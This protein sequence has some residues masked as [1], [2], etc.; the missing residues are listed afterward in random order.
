MAIEDI[1]VEEGWR[2]L[3]SM[4]KTEKGGYA[5]YVGLKILLSIGAAIVMGISVLI[6]VLVFL[7]PIGAVGLIAVFGGRAAGLTW[8]LFTLSVAIMAGCVAL[9]AILYAVALLTVPAIVFFPAYSIYFFA[10][11]YPALNT[12]LYA[13][14]A[15]PETSFT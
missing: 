1:S 13:P 4:L 14:A 2:R 5:G 12:M 3:W 9:A 8:N 6:V 7:I 15:S 11:R 10:A